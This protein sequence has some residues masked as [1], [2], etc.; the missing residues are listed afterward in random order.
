MYEKVTMAIY[1]ARS[2]STD[3]VYDVRTTRRRRR[4]C[5]FTYWPPTSHPPLAYTAH[6]KVSPAAL[7][8]TVTRLL[9][10]TTCVTMSAKLALSR[11]RRHDLGR[12]GENVGAERRRRIEVSCADG[13]LDI[14]LVQCTVKLRTRPAYSRMTSLVIAS[15]SRVYSS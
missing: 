11:R 10:I 4:Y 9:A 14:Y 6:A 1:N 2:C 3:R 15:L 13:T 8:A 5:N 7:P 12:I